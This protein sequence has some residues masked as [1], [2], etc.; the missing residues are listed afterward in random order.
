MQRY[1]NSFI[2]REDDISELCE[3]L[4]QPDCRLL[5]IVGSGGMGKT[6]LSQQIASQQEIQTAYS[7]GVY[8]VPL[9]SL[10]TADQLLSALANALKVQILSGDYKQALFE[11]MQEKTALFVLDNFEHLLNTPDD[12]VVLLISDLLQNTSTVDLLITSREPLNL[13]EEWVYRVEG[14]P[15][16]SA[17]QLFNERAGQ[18]QRTFNA[19]VERDSVERICKL[20]DGL[21][22]AIEL[23]AALRRSRTTEHILRDLSHGIDA[24]QSPMRNVP[25]RHRS[26]RVIFDESW[27]GLSEAARDVFMKLSVF[28]GSFTEIAAHDLAGAPLHTLS[29][30]VEKSLISLAADGSGRYSVHELLRQYAAEKLQGR[31]KTFAPTTAPIT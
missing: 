6:R 4:A 27:A 21:P 24:L 5:T 3:R 9:V 19:H 13:V 1:T 14:L 30:L 17:V 28:Q 2:G 11:V 22:L 20:L 25:Q 12:S 18:A 7:D 15:H 29:V 8:F 31:D 23:A 10:T 16:E 26:V